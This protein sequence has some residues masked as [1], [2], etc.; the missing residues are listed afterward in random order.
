MAAGKGTGGGRAA[1]G[2][3]GATQPRTD[4]SC[5]W[6]RTCG[7]QG[8]AAHE[9]RGAVVQGVQLE[10]VGALGR[11]AAPIVHRL[12]PLPIVALLLCRLLL[13]LLGRLAAAARAAGARA[14]WQHG[15]QLQ[16]APGHGPAQRQGQRLSGRRAAQQLALGHHRL[17][18]STAALATRPRQHL[19]AQRPQ[20]LAGPAR[21]A[22]RGGSRRE[23]RRARRA[24]AAPHPA[25]PPHVVGEGGLVGA[26]GW[27]EREVL[28]VC[29]AGV[30][31]CRV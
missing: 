13:A 31:E 2:I 28:E 12:Q 17:V 29:W 30:G 7:A 10:G 6:C 4:T 16:L 27:R 21:D 22:R 8:A 11:A 18:L 26:R 3:A 15:A 14:G 24:A 23:G 9:A 19:L 25:P 5:R 1:A 20:G